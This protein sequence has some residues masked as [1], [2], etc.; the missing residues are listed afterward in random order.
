MQIQQTKVGAQG[1]NKLKLSDPTRQAMPPYG[2]GPLSLLSSCPFTELLI[3]PEKS[4]CK[5]Y[6]FIR[7][8][9][10]RATTIFILW[11]QIDLSLHSGEGDFGA[12]YN[13]II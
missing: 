13:A 3:Y 2:Y 11:D 4:S 5:K 7:K 9:E 10:H 12:V 8:K 6:G 1:I